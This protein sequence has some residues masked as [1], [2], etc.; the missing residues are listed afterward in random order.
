MF[1]GMQAKQTL[2]SRGPQEGREQR[3]GGSSDLR[4]SSY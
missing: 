1:S 2:Q 4:K 3:N